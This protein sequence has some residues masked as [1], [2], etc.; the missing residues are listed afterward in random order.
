MEKPILRKQ[1]DRSFSNPFKNVAPCENPLDD[2]TK[3]E[4]LSCSAKLMEKWK[5]N[6]AGEVNST[7]VAR[8]QSVYN[9]VSG[10]AL[11]YLELGQLLGNGGY[12]E[13]AFFLAEKCISHL[14]EHHLTFLTGDTGP[15]SIIAVCSNLLKQP[16]KEQHYIHRLEKMLHSSLLADRANQ[17]PDELL[18]GRAG[19]LY[20]LLYTKQFVGKKIDKHL[21]ASLVKTILE[22]GIRLSN[23]C[24]KQGY[25]VPPLMF[26][27][28]GSKYLA[29]AH[30]MA[31][32]FYILFKAKNHLDQDML[33]NYVRPSLDYLLQVR[34]PGGN[35]PSSLENDRDRLV[36]WCHGA[37]G[38]IHCLVEASKVYRSDVY[39]DAAK[40][41]A[42]VTWER[43]V[44]T[45]GFGLC[46]GIAGNAYGFL[47]I[48]QHTGDV[49]YLDRAVK[50]ARIIIEAPPHEFRTADHPSSLYEGLA[51]VIHFL[52]SLLQPEKARFPGYQ[53]DTLPSV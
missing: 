16:E 41:C 46:H 48:Y 52:Y 26:E 53:L 36:Q 19:C 23:E 6:I 33:E 27:W 2:K 37:P 10:Y 40:D 5:R 20:S 47:H 15:L 43:G 1:D 42:D 22:S 7:G 44:L 31:G 3:A 11:L 24:K 39:L 49:V 50:F 4:I 29:A 35:L 12:I 8:D 14:R 17:L 38:F 21:I 18:Y 13:Q 25:K 45:K 51:G 30:G 9:G 34:F 32:I 28:H